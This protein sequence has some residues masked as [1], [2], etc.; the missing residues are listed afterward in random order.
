MNQS[1]ESEIQSD[2]SSYLPLQSEI[3]TRLL[4]AS[5]IC[6]LSL[7]LVSASASTFL[8][9]YQNSAKSLIYFPIGLLFAFTALS[10]IWLKKNKDRK[11]FLF[12]QLSA[13]LITITGAVYITGAYSSPFIFLYLPLVMAA[14]VTASQRVGLTLSAVSIL[15]YALLAVLISNGIIPT[16]DGDNIPYFSG[17]KLTFQIVGLGSGMILVTVLT[18]YLAK[19]MRS[20]RA[21]IEQ[22]QRN[23]QQL[24]H[25]QKALEEQ[26]QAQD[27]MARLL[28]EK[29]PTAFSSSINFGE[30]VG[31]SLVMRKVF[32]LIERVATSDATVLISGE[33]GTGKELVARAIHKGRF[34]NEAPFVA[35]NCGA[36]PENLIESQLFGH[37]KGAFTGAEADY[38]GIFVQAHGGTIFLDEIGELPLLMQTKLLRAIQEKSVRPI[39]GNKDIPINVRIIAASNRNLKKEVELGNFREDLFYRLNVITIKLPPLRARREDIPLLVNSILRKFLPAGIQA[40]IPP[41]SMALLLAYHYPGNVRELENIL[42]RAVVLGGEIILPEHLPASLHSTHVGSSADLLPNKRTETQIIIDESIELPV[43][44][45][46]ILAN[47]EQRY[48]EVALLKSNGIKKRA[49]ELLG[50]NFRSF[51]YRLQKFGIADE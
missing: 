39:G 31:E 51:R 24:S 30:F 7:A 15:S 46:Q 4:L 43:N 34:L 13:D 5:R 10:A 33:S 50:I 36:I 44:L 2:K 17:A 8:Y 22:S 11:E 45:E 6:L 42:E 40:V 32:A 19:I 47:I 49:A 21:I 1:I 23:I 28:A 29:N 25:S 37:K 35:V 41:T 27:R 3:D 14:S 12:I 20:S 48:L 9:D 38:S 26:L 16:A 18:S